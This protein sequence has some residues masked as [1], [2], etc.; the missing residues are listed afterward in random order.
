MITHL[1]G[2]L[3]NDTNELIYETEIESQPQ[4]TIVQSPKGKGTRGGIN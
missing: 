2:I 4:K 1:C 3:K